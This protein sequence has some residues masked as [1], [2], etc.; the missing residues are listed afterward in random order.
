MIN[1]EIIFDSMKLGITIFATL[2]L[3]KYFVYLVIAPFYRTQ[4]E[5]L[6]LKLAKNQIKSGK[7]M[8]YNPLVSIIIPAWNEE[9]GIITTIES[10]LSNTYKNIE[11]I[12]IN[13]GSTDKTH[14][15][16]KSFIATYKKNPKYKVKKLF[17]Y[18]KKNGGKGSALN[19]GIKKAQ[20]EIVVT[21]DADSAH[22]EDTVQNMIKYFEDGTVDAVVG[23]VKVRNTKSLIGLIQYL[24]YIFGFYF[25][26]VHSIF[27]AEYIFGGACAAFRKKTTFDTLGLFDI[28]NKTEDIEYSMRVKINGLKSLYAEDVMTYTEGASDVSGIYKQRLRWKKGRID[29]FIKYRKLF[30]SRDKSHSWFLSWVVL[31]YAVLGEI[32]MLLEPL[33]FTAIWTYT[34]VSKDFLSVGISSLFIGFTY[35]S[36]FIF[37]DRKTNKWG[38]FLFPFT[39]L[40]FYILVAV[41]FAALVKSIELVKKNQDVVWQQWKREGI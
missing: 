5:L 30:F 18:K 17:Y 13:D 28:V 11:I 8:V 3:I 32:Q 7:R 26:R 1:Y 25:K 40:M 4:I 15:I 9:V 16:M 36:A 34:I 35:I 2:V 27:N 38:V 22:S 6:K 19:H 33:F 39:W 10:A 14:E 21:M 41:E 37:G 23:N 20:G 12:V 24:E 31:P 29:T